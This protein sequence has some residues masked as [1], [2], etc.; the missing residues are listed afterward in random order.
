MKIHG[1]YDGAIKVKLLIYIK[2]KSNKVPV[3]KITRYSW[4]FV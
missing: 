2:T 1:I 3:G 4:I